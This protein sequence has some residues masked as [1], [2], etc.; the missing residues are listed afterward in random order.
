[1]YSRLIVFV[2]ILMI[3]CCY[4]EAAT[5][6]ETS[7]I[8]AIEND[9]LSVV[10]HPSSGMITVRDKIAHFDWQQ[11]STIT[12]GTVGSEKKFRRARQIL[13]GITF[14]TDLGDN[15][16]KP[17]TVDMTMTL[18]DKGRD[19]IFTIEM[20][21]NQTKVGPMPFVDPFVLDTE[22]G[23]LAIADYSDG[24]LYPLSL[25]PFP[26]QDVAGG[27][28][29]MPWLGICDVKHGFGYAMILDTSDDAFV[30]FAG[31]KVDGIE[32]RSP[33]VIWM[34]RLG[35]F[36]N[37]RKITYHF[38]SKGGYVALAKAYREYAKKNGLLVTLE[39]KAK[40]NPNV[41]R[42]F[43][44]P[45]VWGN[46]S[47]DFVKEAQFAGIDKMLIHGKF[48][49]EEMRTIS[50]KGFLTSNYDNY[51]DVL[52]VKDDQVVDS[53]HDKVPD[54]VVLNAD[55]SRKTAWL[56]LDKTQYMKR[57]PS[58]WLETAKKAIPN[59]LAKYPY[60]GRFIDVTTAEDLYE[61]YDE[62]HQLTRESKRNAG[63]ALLSYVRSLDLVV[64]GEHG[65][66]W[67]VPYL[68]YIE[69]MMSGGFTPWP[70]GHL[71]RPKSRKDVFAGSNSTWADYEKYSVGYRY[72]VPLWEL[73]F[74]DCVVSTWYWGDSSDYLLDAAPEVQSRKDAYNVLYGT[75]P[76]L[77]ANDEGSWKKDK[78]AFLRSYR[79]TCKLH[80]EL[81]GKEMLY[82]EYLTSDLT[83]QRTYWSDGTEI[84]VN[85][86]GHY[87]DVRLGNRNHSLPMNGFVVKGP[88]IEQ[89]LEYINGNKVTI[90][91]KRGYQYTDISGIGI[92]MRLGKPGHM[93][94]NIG[95]CETPVKIHPGNLGVNWDLT[96]CKAW[97]L[98][99][100][101]NRVQEVDFKYNRDTKKPEFI[102]LGPFTQDTVIDLEGVAPNVE[103]WKSLF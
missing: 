47:L 31:H 88:N 64:G 51:T 52:P 78:E 101:G 93:I 4:A 19:L 56:T 67:G 81:A 74:H 28:L 27:R 85:F 12:G 63:M 76:L 71:V 90:I 42:L 65:I 83:V 70:A 59:D 22:S 48:Q 87:R 50:D 96:A 99:K 57:C 84:T 25:Q 75:I 39:E 41:R 24:H 43:G 102:F 66:W 23:A 46:P 100:D 36:G 89:S 15:N 98:D 17:N 72:R 3:F 32:Y 92:T 30:R 37:P 45:D 44:A 77:W 9:Q 40:R 61:C 18:A 26:V 14:E 79:N 33:Q 73:V 29:D 35:K 21:D 13:N 68:D 86:G 11:S 34:P 94:L 60:L 20:A 62:N 5:V 97:K 16:G 38:V 91:R 58:F 82:H 55:G 1:M 80:E 95:K 7:G 69:G 103:L 10:V 54:H 2:S 53:S 8:W 49:P 6:R